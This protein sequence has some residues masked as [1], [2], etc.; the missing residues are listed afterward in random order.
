[1]SGVGPFKKGDGLMG[2]AIEEV[3]ERLAHRGAELI[4]DQIGCIS[5]QEQGE[6]EQLLDVDVAARYLPPSR[7]TIHALSIVKRISEAQ[8]VGRQ[9]FRVEDSEGDSYQNRCLA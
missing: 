2:S 1:M 8:L 4:F 9:P 5:S 3:V 6:E 7:S